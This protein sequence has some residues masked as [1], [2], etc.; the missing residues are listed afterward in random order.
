MF[1]YSGPLLSFVVVAVCL[2]INIVRYP[3][4]WEMLDKSAYSDSIA[5]QENTESNEEPQKIE[6]SEQKPETQI[7]KSE[8]SDKNTLK[9]GSSVPPPLGGSPSS[10]SAPPSH[11]TLSGTNSSPSATTNG[12]GPIPAR[13]AP[14]RKFADSAAVAKDEKEVTPQEEE[15]DA[16]A[17]EEPVEVPFEEEPEEE[18]VED[19]KPS[20]PLPAYS[21]KHQPSEPVTPPEPAKEMTPEEKV[22]AFRKS[23]LN[24]EPAQTEEF[25]EAPEW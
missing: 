14:N 11:I 13:S 15:P 22:E 6:Q 1:R 12:Y 17:E 25:T 21:E 19:V 4:V 18:P 10:L 16:F 24:L 7:A 8:T 2:G 20:Q 3:V 23:P 9:E 5:S